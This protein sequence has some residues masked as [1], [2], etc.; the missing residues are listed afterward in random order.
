MI[1]HGECGLFKDRHD[2]GTQLAQR[3]PYMIPA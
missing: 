2:A 3:L 1:P